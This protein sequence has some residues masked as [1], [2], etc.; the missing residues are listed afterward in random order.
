MAQYHGPMTDAEIEVAR[1]ELHALRSD[2]REALADEL[3]GD[4]DDYRADRPVADG[5]K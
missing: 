1:E 4:A 2:V 5:G 3:S